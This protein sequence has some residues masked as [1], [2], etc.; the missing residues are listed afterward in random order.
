MKL[1]AHGQICSALALPP[2]LYFASLALVFQPARGWVRLVR[3]EV[4]PGPD[5][6]KGRRFSPLRSEGATAYSF[7][8]PQ[9]FSAREEVARSN[10]YPQENWFRRGLNLAHELF[11]AR[12]L[13]RVYSDEAPIALTYLFIKSVN[14]L[15]AAVSVIKSGYHFQSWPLLRDS[16]EAAELMDYF[17]RNPK[18]IR[19]WLDK[20]KR[21]DG[22]SWVRNH[23]PKTELRK[24]LFDLLNETSH[25]NF[26]NIDALSTWESGPN[27]RTLAVGPLPFSTEEQLPF[28]VAA[29]LISYPVR[30]LWLHEQDVVSSDWVSKF[31]EFDSATGFVLGDDW[32][33]KSADDLVVEPPNTEE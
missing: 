33:A 26:R 21:F 2:D 24:Q 22:L 10:S 20:E 31:N 5:Q 4:M 23:L 32:A 18:E 9:Y 14:D 11:T 1:E 8:P 7:E 6:T 30:V 13:P 25:A 15:L 29:S 16:L 17:K 19:G 3:R 27:E 28:T 12:A